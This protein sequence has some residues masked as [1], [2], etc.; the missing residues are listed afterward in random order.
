M[1]DIEIEREGKQIICVLCKDVC[2]LSSCRDVCVSPDLTFVNSKAAF[3]DTT[4]RDELRECYRYRRE[5]VFGQKGV[6]YD[7]G[8]KDF[9]PFYNSD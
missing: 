2:L 9:P 7:R 5:R 8:A 3:K 6:K 1:N 4:F